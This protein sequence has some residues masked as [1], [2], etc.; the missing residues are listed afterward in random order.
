MRDVDDREPGA[1]ELAKDAMQVGHLIGAERGRGLVEDEEARIVQQRPRDLDQLAFGG[2]QAG[3][4]AVQVDA[5][6]E[7]REDIAHRPSLGRV[8]ED[9]E[10]GLFHAEGDILGHRELRYEVRVLEDHADPGAHRLG[11]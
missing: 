2:A 11:P 3:G 1:A 5:R 10:A 7:A 9:A 4:H 6:S 8:A